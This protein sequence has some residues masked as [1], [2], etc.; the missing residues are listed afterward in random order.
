MPNLRPVIRLAVGLCLAV[1]AGCA[2][3]TGTCDLVRIT[4]LPVETYNRLPIVPVG[5]NGQWTRLLV[6]TGAE[7]TTLSDAAVKRLGM[8]RDDRFVSRSGGVGGITTSAD[9]KVDSLVMGGV[10][11]PIERLAVS[12]FGEGLPV[13]GLLGA[14][15][16]LAFDL[17]IDMPRG[18]LALYRVRRCADSTPPWEGRF[19]PITGVAAHRDRMVVPI[20]LDGFTGT[21][22]LDT[23][24]QATAIGVDMARRMGLTE[25]VLA[26]DP[27]T[28]VRGVGPGVM[29]ARMRLFRE[30]RVGP[31]AQQNVVL[32]VLPTDVGIGDALIGQDFLRHRRVWMSFPTRQ[33]FVSELAH[34][35]LARR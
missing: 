27:A 5:I 17:D 18:T 23:G 31:V 16:L 25:Q 8:A 7:R 20:T 22:I 14:D 28:Q 6:D 13:D 24:A 35:R 11:F 19:V 26:D 30:L 1:L 21:A 9:A 33:L 29:S 2:D 32:P 12:R 34:E 3:G 4:Q 10:R 15:I